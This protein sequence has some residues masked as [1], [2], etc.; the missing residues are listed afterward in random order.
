MT[1]HVLDASALLRG[2]LGGVGA[3]RVEALLPTSAVT[4]V[5]LS[6]VVTRLSARGVPRDE[7]ETVLDGLHLEAVPVD[8]DLAM[9]AAFVVT[10]EEVLGFEQRACLALAAAR[11]GV[12]VTARNELRAALTNGEVE[13]LG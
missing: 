5:T 13:F 3:D 8:R 10:G 1:R 2:L 12:A 6:E 4:A 11:G 9:A 7:I